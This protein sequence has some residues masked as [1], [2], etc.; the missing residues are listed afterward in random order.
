MDETQ[1]KNDPFEPVLAEYMLGIDR[2]EQVDREEFIAAH[3]DAADRLRAYFANMDAVS[4]MLRTEIV[5]HGTKTI[6]L[7]PVLGDYEILEQ[8]GRGGMG[9]STALATVCW[10]KQSP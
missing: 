4:T 1:A 6:D 8:I 5:D 10:R 7:P 3:P 2:G 9:V